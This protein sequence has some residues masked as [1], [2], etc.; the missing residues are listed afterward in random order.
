MDT[1]VLQEQSPQGIEVAMVEPEIVRQIRALTALGW[2]SRRIAGELGIAHAQQAPAP[3]PAPVPVMEA[4]IA[5]APA[6]MPAPQPAPAPVAAAPSAPAGD[7]I[8][9]RRERASA[10]ASRWSANSRTMRS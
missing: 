3:Q 5:V 9:A 2:G 4:P 6:P 8:A 7:L 1:D 10:V